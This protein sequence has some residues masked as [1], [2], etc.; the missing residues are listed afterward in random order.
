MEKPVLMRLENIS[1]QY[2]MGEVI[3]EALKET[4]LD[5]YAGE[6]LV[7]VGPSGSGKSTLL[8]LVGGMDKP[9]SGQIFFNGKELSVAGDQD[10][11][12]YR[13][14]EIGFVFQFYNLIPDLTA[15]EN[16]ALAA[17]LVEEP[18]TVDEALQGVGLLER[19]RHFPSQLSGGEQQRVSIARALVKKPHFLLC[20]EP[21]GALDYQTGKSILGLLDR[22][23]NMGTTVIIVTHNTAIAAMA[24]R[25]IR[26]RSGD[27]IE[28][29]VNEN[30]LPP[31]RIEW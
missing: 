11:T 5:I 2:H 10:L 4:S 9:S 27:I 8:N 14:Q 24:E 7:I 29:L 23:K 30:P 3:V 26:M 20:D 21:T 18:L 22:V 12:M 15:A 6:L 25:V 13:R 1:K 31:E 16:V 28:V 17:E 19:S